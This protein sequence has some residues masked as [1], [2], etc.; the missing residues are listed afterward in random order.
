MSFSLRYPWLVIVAAMILIISL[1]TGATKLSFVSDFR[2]YFSADNPQLLS[3]EQLEKD[4]NKQDTLTFLLRPSSS[5]TVLDPL[6]LNE[7]AQLTQAAWEI[8]YARRVDS[9][10]NYQRIQSADDN[11]N[12][13]DFYRPEQASAWDIAGELEYI[14]TQPDLLNRLVNKD[15]DLALIIVSLSL[16]DGDEKAT[17][18]LVAY[19]REL[20]AATELQYLD[21]QLFGTAII[22]LALAEAVERDM[23]ALIPAS[24]LLIFAGI[25]FLTRS[26]AGTFLALTL[27]LL[28]VMATFGALG[29]AG[30]L[31]LTTARLTP[32]VGVV[33]SMIM[34]IVIA[35]CLHILATYQHGLRAGMS[36]V[37]A[38]AEAVKSNIRPVW[39]TSITT[40]L[41]LLCLNFSESPP[42]RDLGNLVAFAALLAAVLSLT[43]FI[44]ALRVLPQPKIQ[45]GRTLAHPGQWL[46]G[47]LLTFWQ[48]VLQP[49]PRALLLGAVIVSAM[50]AAGVSQLKFNEQWHQYYDESFAVRQALDLQNDKLNGVNFIQYR[51]AA[52]DGGSLYRTEPMQQ[53]QQLAEHLETFAEVGFV[54]SLHQPLLTLNQA[55]HDGDKNYYR[56]PASDEQVAQAMLLYEMSLPFGM[57]LNERLTIDQTASRFTVHLFKRTS[58]ELV[59]F[60]QALLDWAAE[61]TPA[62]S[63]APGSGL[64]MVFAQISD[65]NSIS[66]F[67]GTLLALV[68]ISAVMMLVLRSVRLGLIS[69]VPNLLPALLAY[70]IWGYISGHVDLGLSIVACMSLGLVVDDTVHFL[71]KY[72]SARA[73][74]ESTEAAI[75]YAFSTVGVAMIITSL[76]LAAGFALLLLSPFSPTWGMGGLMALT[77]I[78]ALLA[79][80]ILLPLL[81]MLLDRD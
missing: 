5:A 38:L 10:T 37:P 15:G 3:F 29:W 6:A 4:F 71:A 70:G 50:L 17:A 69:L 9:L 33:P 35:D 52:Q 55:L 32:V 45:P 16:P 66:L 61:H 27:T 34:I 67:Q 44:A 39:I 81:L 41:G 64:D 43:L 48:R 42:Y 73:R 77:V 12:I 36:K 13:D 49:H 72:R 46:S 40:A 65:R 60:D 20:L 11:I 47:L 31:G 54:D 21:V 28:S 51:I 80:L 62:L 25:F 78:V 76:V 23:E 56:I 30:A 24:Y 19:T 26:L 63:I 2:V 75:E 74:G 79:D 68:L 59:A 58:R 22:N 7:I 1:T 18:E 8:P 53:L 57:G 14:R